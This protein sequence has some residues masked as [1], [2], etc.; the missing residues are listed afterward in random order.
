MKAGRAI[1]KS[2]FH[3]FDKINS[4]YDPI[5]R[6]FSGINLTEKHVHEQKQKCIKLAE[7]SGDCANLY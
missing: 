3:H 6:I 1:Q 5:I 7:S 2:N 4:H